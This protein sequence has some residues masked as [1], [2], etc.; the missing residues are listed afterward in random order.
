MESN[1][2]EGTSA[3]D[4][5]RSRDPSNDGIRNSDQSN[6]ATVLTQRQES[7]QQAS[8]VLPKSSEVRTLELE[9]QKLNLQIQYEKLL[10]ARMNAERL[11]GTLSNSGSE[12]GDQRRRGFDSVQQCAKVL[13]G[14]RLP[15]DAD[16]PLWF[17]EVETLFATYQVPHESRVHLVM[18]ALT[19]RVRYLLRNLNPEESADYE[20]VKA[21]VLTELKLSPAEYLQR[22]ER[23][24]K[25][26]FSGLV[27]RL[28]TID[29]RAHESIVKKDVVAWVIET[30]CELSKGYKNA[31]E[32]AFLP[33]L[34]VY[35]GDKEQGLFKVFEKP[36]FKTNVMS[37]S[38]S[39]SIPP[40]GGTKREGGQ[41]SR[42]SVSAKV[43]KLNHMLQAN[44]LSEQLNCPNQVGQSIMPLL[45]IWSADHSIKKMITAETMDDVIQ[46]ARENGICNSSNAK[47]FLVFL[48][49]WTELEE[50]VFQ[51]VLVQL[52]MDQRI[53]VV[54][55]VAPPASSPV[56]DIS[57]RNDILLP[58]P[59]HDIS[60]SVSTEKLP[61]DL[62]CTLSAAASPLDLK[63]RRQLNA[64]RAS[65]QDYAPLMFEHMKSIVKKDVM[66]WVIE[67]ERELSKG[68]KNAK[69]GCISTIAG[70]VLWG[71][72]TEALQGFREIVFSDKCYVAC[73]QELFCEAS[74]FTE[75]VCVMFLTY[76][77]F[78]MMDPNSAATTLEFLQ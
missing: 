49:D 47:V 38:C 16:V 41:Q 56:Q 50:A 9:I 8:Q 75:A 25:R 55:E 10:Q 29:V 51:E 17:E 4:V 43:M 11:N 74:D 36:S 67:T 13:K 34:A 30:E 44:V 12:T 77:A 63:H 7:M 69:E 42:T 76:Y 3:A 26:C 28:R 73:K 78:N 71:Q 53:F 72:R 40:K 1:E 68:Y 20:S 18:P 2:D 19:E 22:F 62:Q 14:F 45:K 64:F 39:I 59:T 37:G 31:K 46:K 32:V 60:I 5:N 6:E 61:K 58:E 15:S 33:L 35:F 52:S 48:L 70:C 57:E 21:A 65:L 54:A 66:A 24:V 27:A 23:A